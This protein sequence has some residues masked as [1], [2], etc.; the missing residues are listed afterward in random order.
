MIDSPTPIPDRGQGQTYNLLS[1]FGMQNASPEEQNEFL[2]AASQAVLI[3]VVGRIEKKLPEDKRE[4][5]HRLFADNASDAEKA[6]FFTAYIPDFKDI[7]IE[8][9]A[10]FNREAIDTAA[11]Q[12]KP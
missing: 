1:L 8:E 4:E 6:A 7:L 11:D 3:A 5:F 9:L 10:R 12:I 2:A